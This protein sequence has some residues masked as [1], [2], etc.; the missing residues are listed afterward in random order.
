M[1]C[2]SSLDNA[3][4]PVT[5]ALGSAAGGDVGCDCEKCM[6]KDFVKSFFGH[7][8]HPLSEIGSRNL[9]GPPKLPPA[10]GPAPT[11]LI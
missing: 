8:Y 9:F 3:N 5:L 1:T 6:L 4:H 2:L 7:T 10:A 11:E